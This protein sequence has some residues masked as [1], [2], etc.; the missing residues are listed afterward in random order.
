VDE[1]VRFVPGEIK[2]RTRSGGLLAECTVGLPR[3]RVLCGNPCPSY[4]YTSFSNT[5]GMPLSVGYGL[6]GRF[7]LD[8]DNCSNIYHLSLRPLY[9]QRRNWPKMKRLA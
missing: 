6:H 3:K 9:Y 7:I 8:K 5:A 2:S 4:G 1:V